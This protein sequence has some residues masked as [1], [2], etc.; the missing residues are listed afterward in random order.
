MMNAQSS[1]QSSRGMT[2]KRGTALL[3]GAFLGLAVAFGPAIKPAMAE[4][5]GVAAAVNPDAFSSLSSTPDKQLK[6][7]KSI[8][9]NERINTTNSGL[10]QVLLVDGSTFT[11]GPNSNLTIDRFVYDPRKKTGEIVATFS[12]G[13]MRFIGGKLSK[14][15]GGVKVKTPAG[16]LAIRGGM[17]DARVS[18]RNGIFAFRYGVSL[19]FTGNNGV[20]KNV[21]EQGYVLDLTGNSI[22]V[23]PGTPEDTQLFQ[24]AFA[25]EGTVV[26]GGQNQPPNN[27]QTAFETISLQDLIADA[28]AT[29]VQ[30]EIDK[31]IE[32][33]FNKPPPNNNTNNNTNSDTNTPPETRQASFGYAGGVYTQFSGS[34]IETYDRTTYVPGDYDQDEP[35]GTLSNLSPTEVGLLFDS[36]TQSFKG[37]NFTLFVDGGAQGRG[38]AEVTFLPLDVIP[39]GDV[40]IDNPDELQD[41]GLFA[42]LAGA[43]IPNSL[44]IFNNTI[45]DPPNPPQLSDPA[46]LNSG[47]VVLV[48]ATGAGE[49]LCE[50]CSFLTWGFWASVADL[51]LQ[52]NPGAPP[53][54]VRTVGWWVTG[55]VINDVVGA[56]PTS[57]SAYYSGN[58]I[59]DVAALQNDIWKTYV[60]TGKVNM[61]WNFGSRDGTFRIGDFDKAHTNGLNFTAPINMPGPTGQPNKFTG[62]FNGANGSSGGV[63]GSFVRGPGQV[64]GQVPAGAIGNWQGGNATYKAGGIWGTSLTQKPN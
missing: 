61:D 14:N 6:I 37:A 54:N 58:T 7:G 2:G 21:F 3:L 57:G 41:I 53:D 29:Q 45:V 40:P 48:G 38:G 13:T 17:F 62:T 47:G 39:V 64:A 52:D 15:E 10:V 8:F 42:G 11:V 9:Y 20:R 33:I 25:G 34:Y 49:A 31:Q 16:A 23:R 55:D 28:T 22:I 59:A 46:I 27:N 63:T 4:K 26:V 1:A 35:A 36:N 50:T 12:K 60:A 32:N 19:S 51:N 43:G 24:S 44:T 18:G 30:D 56:L 5:V